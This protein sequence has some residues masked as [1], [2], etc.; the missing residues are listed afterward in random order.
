MRI[1]RASL[2]ALAGCTAANP[3][4]LGG[5][6]EADLAQPAAGGDGGAGDLAVA[7]GRD[8]AIPAP[9]DLAMAP[10]DLRRP[11]GPGA[12]VAEAVLATW[13]VGESLD[14]NLAPCNPVKRG[15]VSLAS[16]MGRVKVGKEAVRVDYGP[17]GINYFQAVY[18]KGG[19][20]GWDLSGRTGVTFLLDAQLP[21]T[22]SGWS[23]AGPTVVLCGP[24]GSYRVLSPAG[25]LLPRDGL[26][27]LPVMVPLA[28]GGSWLTQDA[29]GFSLAQVDSIELHA[30]PL[31]NLGTG[32]C[33]VWLDDVRFY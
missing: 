4:Y 6:G 15:L 32:T 33:H 28:G 16:E 23:P 11:N 13:D 9:P 19:K 18:P 30:N 7:P 14:N 20:A 22:F 21:P 26:G 3:N 5:G 2:L 10:P 25:N 17:D 1:L 31:K 12:D 27:Y 24:N 29:G 8:M